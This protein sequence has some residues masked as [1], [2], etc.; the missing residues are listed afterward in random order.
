MSGLLRKVRNRNRPGTAMKVTITVV[1]TNLRLT[2][3]LS[4]HRE[5]YIS[6]QRNKKE[7]AKTKSV[8]P[9]VGGAIMF[10]EDI[11]FHTIMYG[12]PGEK[13]EPKAF[14][15]F[16][17]MVKDNRAFTMAQGELDLAEFRNAVGEL[18]TMQLDFLHS[19]QVGPRVKLMITQ[20]QLDEEEA[21]EVLM[22]RDSVALVS[23][24]SSSPPSKN[25]AHQTDK[26]RFFRARKKVVSV[27][28]SSD[29][30]A[31]GEKA[32]L[33]GDEPEYVWMRR[34]EQLDTQLSQGQLLAKRLSAY[35][36]KLHQMHSQL[37]KQ[38]YELTQAEIGFFRRYAEQNTIPQGVPSDSL[39]QVL[40]VLES[41]GGMSSLD[42]TAVHREKW[43]SLSNKLDKFSEGSQLSR[44]S[45]LQEQRVLQ[46]E[47]AQIRG[48]ADSR[49]AD[50]ISALNL[51]I[52]AASKANVQALVRAE[53]MPYDDR[54]CTSARSMDAVEDLVQPIVW[55]AEPNDENL[56][57]TREAADKASTVCEEFA[58]IVSRANEKLPQHEDGFKQL[59]RRAEQLEH[60]R[61]AETRAVLEEFVRVRGEWLLASTEAL[62]TVHAKVDE[63]A[64]EP[65]LR[66]FGGGDDDEKADEELSLTL[67]YALSRTPQQ[68]RDNVRVIGRF[69]SEEQR[70]D[71]LNLPLAERRAEPMDPVDPEEAKKRAIVQN[72]KKRFQEMDNTKKLGEEIQSML[73]RLTWS[74]YYS[75]EQFGNFLLAG[76]DVCRAFAEH[77]ERFQ[78]TENIRFFHAAQQYLEALQQGTLLDAERSE[79]QQALFHTYIKLM[80]PYQVNIP[81]DIKTRI[82]TALGE[83]NHA[84]FD[85]ALR[86]AFDVVFGLMRK[87][88]LPTFMRSLEFATVL[89]QQVLD[90]GGM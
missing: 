90:A 58:S 26:H 76:T 32:A 30:S 56:Q 9:D 11:T 77:L 81:H 38:V 14:T 86:E 59:L 19:N 1:S 85:A 16:I 28:K 82:E 50:A 25:K 69:L 52:A 10:N 53:D 5:V 51:S 62:N 36:K 12:K 29:S 87:N 68:L 84:D 18:Y 23:T 79:Q 47:L 37:S 45:A 74:A 2:R 73:Q 42:A 55:G 66:A 60:E 27:A 21:K 89:F 72:E 78:R 43:E 34:F 75:K 88:S 71:R 31:E 65:T 39:E 49:R 3:K 57:A 41:V 8:A 15:V 7:K 80:S 13:P 64:M 70:R 17:K 22:R 4:E 35:F 33:V 40:S 20:E 54:D 63:I 6:F 48:E 83:K 46:K 61:I 24:R 44:K 67:S